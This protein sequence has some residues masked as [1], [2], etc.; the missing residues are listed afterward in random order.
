MALVCDEYKFIYFLAPGTG[1]SAIYK[2]FMDNFNVKRI[3]DSDKNIA[4]EDGKTIIQSKHS[5]FQE[6]K[7]HNLLDSEQLSYLKITGT[8]N[9][10]DYFYAE[11]YRSRTRFSRNLADESSWIYNT[12]KGKQRIGE[13]IDSL[14]LEFPDWLEKRLQ[15]KYDSKQKAMLHPQ[16][17]NH[18]DAFIRMENMNQ[19]IHD[20]LLKHCGIDKKVDVNKTN[21]TPRD[22][23]YWQH[24]SWSARNIVQTVFR[25]YINKFNYSF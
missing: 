2:Y 7:E 21:V 8:R 3:P 25:P 17:V 12:P 4:S 18:A 6:L 10:Y 19:D 23:C 20:I 1:S 24:Y 22:R 14:L 11:W 5:T 16:Y 13:I 9:P 15:A